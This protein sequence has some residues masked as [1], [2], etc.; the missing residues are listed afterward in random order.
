MK[1]M[2]SNIKHAFRSLAAV[3]SLLLVGTGIF[4]QSAIEEA[5]FAKGFENVRHISKAG[6]E[7]IF[8]E[9][10]SFTHGDRVV[11]SVKNA[12]ETLI[13]EFKSKNIEV[14]LMEERI[15][16]FRMYS[17]LADDPSSSRWYSD[18]NVEE[19][20][21]ALNDIDGKKFENSSFGK[22][23]LKFYPIFR[24]KNSRLDVM[25]LLQL[26][27]N[28]T[29]EIS[30]WRGATATA[31]VIFP[32]LNDYSTEEGRIR[33]GFLTLSQQFRLPF[34]I[35]AMATV[36]NFNMFRAGAD[37]K[38]Y[39][40]VGSRTGVY[41]QFS[42]TAY[43]VPFFND[44]Y[45]TNPDKFTWKLGANYIVKPWNLMFNLNLAKYLGNDLSV[46]GEVTRYFRNAA[47]G[48]YVQTMDIPDFPVNGGFYFAISL[49]PYKHKRNK[50]VRVSAGNYFPLEYIARPYTEHGR[51]FTTSPDENSS[52]NFFT[53][54]R[55]NQIILNS[56]NN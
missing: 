11:E 26:N 46:R 43:S 30:L 42:Y 14:I 20:I 15:P 16:K 44:W 47:V 12:V 45:Y 17:T 50:F 39:K 8:I 24:F 28:P 52:Y 1:S 41:A 54:M 34:N 27:I 29:L 6:K 3:L 36:G 51:Y 2:L 35:H 25:Y 49:P 32:L 40:P 31:Q 7:I 5:L 33:P 19:G 37:L 48:F 56:T 21:A 9:S 55:L 23:D 53:K 38:L 22:V 10:E 4:A 18:F 13:P